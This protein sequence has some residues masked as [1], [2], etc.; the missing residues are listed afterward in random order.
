MF[1]QRGLLLGLLLLMSS[2]LGFRGVVAKDATTQQAVTQ[3]TGAAEKKLT[4]T[5][6]P[7]AELVPTFI[8]ILML[9]YRP[10]P[11]ILGVALEG[12]K[13]ESGLQ[14]TLA[15]GARWGRRW[16]EVAWRAVEPNEGELHW[17]VLAGLE[18]ELVRAR[19]VGIQP[20]LEVQLTP[21]WAQQHKGHAC[22][23]IRGDKFEAFARFMEE[24]VKRYGTATRYGVRYWQLA[25]EMD[26]D[27]RIVGGDSLFGCWGELEDE[28]YGGRHYGEMLKVVY[29]RIKAADPGAIVMMGGLLLECDPY[30]MKPGVDCANDERWKSGFFLEGVLKAGAGDYFDM[31]DVHSYAEVRPKL[32]SRMHSYYFWSG[33]NGGTG[34]PEKTAFYRDLFQRYGIP[35]KPIFAGEVALKCE[36]D[37]DDCREVGAAFIPRVYAE[38]YELGLVGATYYALISDFKHKGLLYENKTVKPQYKAYDFMSSML[39]YVD[40]SGPVTEYPGVSGQLFKRSGVRRIQVVWSTSGAEQTITLPADFVQAFDRYGNVLEPTTG[41]L[42]VSWSPIYIELLYQNQK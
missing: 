32:P 8:P 35:N 17:E 7:D 13:D 20:I 4:I 15:L 25:N 12:F 14:E 33:P 1:T 9:D 39:S 26:V 28:F 34:L 22:G 3:Q 37:N 27:Y 30:K 23:P 16:R 24:L 2:L 41:T 6:R 40:H 31:A 18:E 10:Q 5:P 19:N 11:P 29:P 36:E 21:E 42:K 38:A